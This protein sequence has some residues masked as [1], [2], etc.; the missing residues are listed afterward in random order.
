MLMGFLNA[1]GPNRTICLDNW[2][3][4]VEPF[5]NRYGLVGGAMSLWV[6]FKISKDSSYSQCISLYLL[7][8]QYVSSQLFLYY[9]FVLSSWILNFEMLLFYNLPWK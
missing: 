8:D 5:K 7:E 9:I 1:N 3:Q 4:L 2:S 6:G